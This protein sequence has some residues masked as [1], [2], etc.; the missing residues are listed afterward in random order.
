[1][2]ERL[3]HA[4]DL[5]EPSGFRPRYR[6]L[7]P[8]VCRLVRSLQSDQYPP[9]T[10]LTPNPDPNR[11]ATTSPDAVPNNTWP[12]PPSDV[13]VAHHLLFAGLATS[14]VSFLAMGGKRW[15]NH[16]PGNRDR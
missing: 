8:G 1:M 15:V 10:T 16:H 4:P 3:E 6:P 11:V 5:R 13:V 9:L 14:L 12:G 7:N 2:T